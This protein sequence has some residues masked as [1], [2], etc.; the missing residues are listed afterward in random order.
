MERV[1]ERR[2]MPCAGK[3]QKVLELAAPRTTGIKIFYRASCSAPKPFAQ[4]RVGAQSHQQRDRLLCC[5]E[6]EPVD[7]VGDVVGISTAASANDRKRTRHRLEDYPAVSLEPLLARAIVET[8]ELAEKI[9]G[10]H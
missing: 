2:R 8:I 10:S 5:I 9:H 4:C 6:Q 7:A 1:A 3:R